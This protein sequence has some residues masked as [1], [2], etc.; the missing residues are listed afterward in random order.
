M[1]IISILSAFSFTMSSNYS[2]AMSWV[3]NLIDTTPFWVI[4]ETLA[5][6]LSLTFSIPAKKFLNLYEFLLPPGNLKDSRLDI[7][8]AERESAEEEEEEFV[9]FAAGFSTGLTAKI[10]LKLEVALFEL[11][12]V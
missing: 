3:L 9:V 12:L 11:V 4:S 5:L 1:K 10:T 8:S 6:I 2:I 7:S